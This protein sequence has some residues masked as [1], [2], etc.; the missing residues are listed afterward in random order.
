MTYRGSHLLVQSDFENIS[1]QKI[2]DCEAGP[3][4]AA[5]YNIEIR[6]QEGR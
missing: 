1:Q 2:R 3:K 6:A 4:I 5:E